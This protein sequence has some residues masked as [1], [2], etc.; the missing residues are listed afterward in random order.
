MSGARFGALWETPLGL[1]LGSLSVELPLLRWIDEGLL[2]VF[3]LVVGLAAGVRARERRRRADHARAARSRAAAARDRRR[4]RAREPG[5][6][7]RVPAL[8]VAARIAVKPPE[9]S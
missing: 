8:A 5:G 6:M 2:T 3:F 9:Y 1:S 7:T 4:P